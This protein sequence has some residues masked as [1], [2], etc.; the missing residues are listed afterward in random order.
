MLAQDTSP[1]P[2]TAVPGMRP[3]QGWGAEGPPEPGHGGLCA[4]NA[5]H[6]QRRPPGGPGEPRSKG[7]AK[8]LMGTPSWTC[9][10][11]HTRGPWNLTPRSCLRGQSHRKEPF[12]ASPWPRRPIPDSQTAQT[13]EKRPAGG[14][15]VVVWT[16]S[17]ITTQSH[18]HAA[19]Q[20]P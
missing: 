12:L 20:P 9:C 14:L 2:V 5:R 1:K 19:P 3:R 7:P 17:V 6:S 13:S 8:P 15:W 4:D 16:F 18:R 11:V 10:P